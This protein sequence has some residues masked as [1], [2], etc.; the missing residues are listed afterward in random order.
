ML[1][2]EVV[3]TSETV[4]ATAAR[5]VKVA[6]LAD[7]L[8]RLAPE[9]VLPTVGFLAGEP[10][11]GRIGVGWA[12]LS[13]ATAGT[14]G[15]PSL[16]VSDLDQALDALAA[17]T[18][19]GSTEARARLLGELLG[20]ATPAEDDFIRRLLLGDLR[21]G[22]LE[23]V[24]AEAVAR[25]AGV[26]AAA[27]RRAHML[28]GDL[29][30][31]ATIALTEGAEG[32]AGVGLE[33]LRPLQ[34]MLAS[35]ADTVAEALAGLGLASVE[36]KLD[37]VRVQLH[38]R[39]D[40][41]AV[42]TRNLNDI[43]ARVPELVAV[44]RELTVESVVLDGEALTVGEGAQPR[45][46]Q[47]TMSRVGRLVGDGATPLVP[48]FFDCLHLDGE[49]LVDRP[50]TER[51]AA[52]DAAAG[53][54]RIPG[55]L[56]GDP[57]VAAGV[58]EDALAAGHEG[59]VAK[60]AG[61]VYEAGRRGAAWRKVKRARTLDLVVLGAEWGHGRRQGWLSNLHLGA[62]D[63]AGDFVM[64][65]KTFKGLTDQMLRWQTERFLELETHRSG[66]VVFVRP[67]LV[68]EIALDGVQ[69]SP[70]Y[71]GG[72][73]LR[74]ARV[75]G[76]R[77]DKSPAEADTIDTVRALLGSHAAVPGGDGDGG[78]ADAGPQQQ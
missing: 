32:L 33:V 12:T 28:C 16:T 8:G 69:A 36:W 22:A 4:A 49:D 1:L 42:F 68:V 40:E 31:A 63:P 38:R 53:A 73:A 25:A 46:F 11:Q 57:A 54:W 64:V 67:E 62:R 3:A 35:T 44:A 50:L 10:R 18:G 72:V 24:M 45:A 55:T 56:T 27:V 65:G 26:P 47:E 15:Q 66:V 13:A 5:S 58:L 34:P 2:G 43:T 61:S 60:A 14:A 17:T 41:V 21:Q 30:Q 39:G 37:G 23:G 78:E 29:R 52:L 74:F 59:V 6:A 77:P 20:R 48:W 76:Y 75:K 9:E 19:P 51:L 70:R 71:P 7:L